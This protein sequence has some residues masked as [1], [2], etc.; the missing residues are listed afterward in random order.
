M[1][2]KYPKNIVYPFKI[3]WKVVVPKSYRLSVLQEYDLI[4]EE[5]DLRIRKISP[6]NI[7]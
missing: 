1:Y 6:E 3:W 7:L 5:T 4:L 2:R